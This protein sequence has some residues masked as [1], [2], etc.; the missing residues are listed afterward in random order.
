MR[1]VTWLWALDTPTAHIAQQMR[2]S[3]STVRV[4]LYQA[5]QRLAA[6]PFL[7]QIAGPTES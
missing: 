5:R 7:T 2:I 3:P 6:D 4:H 1:Q